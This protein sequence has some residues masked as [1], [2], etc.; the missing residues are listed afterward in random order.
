MSAFFRTR[1]HKSL[2]TI[3]AIL[4]RRM[5]SQLKDRQENKTIGLI[6]DPFELIV[7]PIDFYLLAPPP[8]NDLEGTPGFCLCTGRNLIGAYLF[9]FPYPRGV[10]T[11]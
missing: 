2:R 5:T 6:V 9:E 1:L 4:S 3:S 8:I 10:K 7:D 11:R